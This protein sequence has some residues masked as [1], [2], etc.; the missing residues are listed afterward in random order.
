MN[1][2]QSNQ[3][4]E[5]ANER[6]KAFESSLDLNGKRGVKG[7]LSAGVDLGTAY[8]VTAVVDD[9]KN[10]VAGALTRSRSS[11]RDGLVFDYLGAISI[12]RQQ[13]KDLQEGGFPIKSAAVAYPPGTTGPNARA[14]GNILE[15]ADLEVV[16]MMDEPSAA[17]LALEITD[18]AVVDVGGGTTGIS[19][20]KDGEVIYSAD[21]A[22]GGVHVDLVLAGNFKIES[23]EAEKLKRDTNRQKE[24]FHLVRPVF[25]KIASIAMRH[26]KGF[27]SIRTIYLVGGTSCFPGIAQVIQ[28]QTGLEVVQPCNPLL[29]TPLGIA[30]ACFDKQMAS[31]PQRPEMIAD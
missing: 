30:L 24:I 9:E 26:L 5:R 31:R 3:V 16:G 4:C 7:P 6:I 13:V 14:F 2:I 28:E 27:P 21:E 18:G 22:T 11:V 15:A 12:L 19:I 1:Q 25:E 23:H 29:V 8:I 20:L 17:S 10:P